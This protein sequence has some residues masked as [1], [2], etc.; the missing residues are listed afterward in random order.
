MEKALGLGADALILDLEDAV[1]PEK[2]NSARD[3]IAERLAATRDHNVQLVVRINPLDSGLAPDDLAAILPHRPDA[4]MLPKAEGAAS[5]ETLVAMAPDLPPII[6]LAAETPA[7]LLDL[8]SMRQCAKHLAG[9]T[10]GAE[11]MAASL[12]ATANR[13]ADG[14]FLAPY[15]LARSMTLVAAHAADVPAI[16]TVYPD[17]R[18][19]EGL[20]R[21]A[22]AAARD[23]FSGMMAIHPEQVPI[24]NAAFTPSDAQIAH[25]RAIVEAFAANPGAGVLRIDGRMVDAPHVRQAQRLLARLSA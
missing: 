20:T 21:Y 2:K 17:I 8:G 24:I 15:Q 16:D 18:D 13:D 6:P 9:L 22:T 3:M 12:G 4:I 1:A 7:G 11:D 14:A 23:G 19:S 5:I 25:A 10:W